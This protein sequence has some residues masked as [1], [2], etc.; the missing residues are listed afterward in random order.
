MLPLDSLGGSMQPFV[1]LHL[2]YTHDVSK[3]PRNEWLRRIEGWRAAERRE[4]AVR[5]QEGAP[6]P[7]RALEIGLDLCSLNPTVV[8]ELDRTRAREVAAAR[9]AWDKLRRRLGWRPAAR[10]H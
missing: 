2:C 5:A 7:I 9:N 1:A 6:E 3:T 4:R 10:N 8:A